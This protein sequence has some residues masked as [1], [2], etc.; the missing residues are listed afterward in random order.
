MG[1]KTEVA[2]ILPKEVQ[3]IADQCAPDKQK[4][5]AIVLNQIFDGTAEW[6][7]QVDSIVVKDVNDKLSI[8]LAATA[9]KSA[10]D[11]RIA[12][13]KII[14]AKRA[15]VQS[16][17]ID[18]T[19]EDKLWLKTKQ[20]MQ[21]Q[22]KAIEDK[23]GL[24]ANY[25][26]IYEAEQKEKRSSSRMQRVADS[27]VEMQFSD[28]ENIT[29]EVFEILLD[30]LIE[31]RDA[32][33]QRAKD[34]EVENARLAVIEAARIKAQEAENERLKA[35]AA[36]RDA[37]AQ[38]ERET[39]A[40]TLALEQAAKAKVEAELKAKVDAENKEKE[41]AAKALKAT[42]EA[43]KEFQLL[44]WVESITMSIPQHLVGNAIA[45][46]IQ[47]KFNGFKKWATLQ[48]DKK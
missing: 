27:G 15:S 18:D 1:T 12:G 22:F 25:V 20:I 8:S 3:E 31:K 43:S 37:E 34:E 5:V 33:L 14:D 4:E 44:A 48:I 29:D 28:Y 13:E 39:A 32:D 19:L 30:G 42:L 45:E 40:K 38:K 35:D 11:A 36:K 24:K 41:E 23:A 46:E 17:M 21:L 10:K 26:K 2:V 16:R 47:K 9:K 7:K 6:S